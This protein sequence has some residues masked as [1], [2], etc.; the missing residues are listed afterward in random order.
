MGNCF[1]HGSLSVSV[2]RNYYYSLS[3]RGRTF[4]ADETRERNSKPERGSY[5]LLRNH[6]KSISSI[7]PLV[8]TKLFNQNNAFHV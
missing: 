7:P 6:C 5:L 2:S 1:L 8:H 3:S 4:T